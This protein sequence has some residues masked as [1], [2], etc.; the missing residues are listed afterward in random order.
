MENSHYNIWLIFDK[1][2]GKLVNL[3]VWDGVTLIWS[4]PSD[5]YAIRLSEIDRSRI[6]L[7]GETLIENPTNINLTD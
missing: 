3:V 4:P 7:N 2:N 5:T 1:A 6:R